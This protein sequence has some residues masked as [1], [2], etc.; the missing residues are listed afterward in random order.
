MATT[1]QR[2][3]GV[4]V[5]FLKCDPQG[6][7]QFKVKQFNPDVDFPD[8]TI[9]TPTERQFMEATA[10]RG[11]LS[12]SERF[13]IEIFNPGSTTRDFNPTASKI[14]IPARLGNLT[15]KTSSDIVLTAL[16]FNKSANAI[17]A[18]TTIPIYPG[19]WTSIGEYVVFP[20]TT[21]ALGNSA[22]DGLDKNNSRV[23]IV[24]FESVTT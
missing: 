20:K 14:S 19:D 24:P 18:G 23:L 13:R 4:L 3:N 5:R 2:M 15:T 9:T 7:A 6:E 17:A 1:V 16:D 21:F 8:I 10:L 22:S 12:E 11:V